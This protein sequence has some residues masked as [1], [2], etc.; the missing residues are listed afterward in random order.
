MLHLHTGPVG[1]IQY[2]AHNELTTPNLVLAASPQ[3]FAVHLFTRI[4]RTSAARQ[5]LFSRFGFS[6]ICLG[7]NFELDWL[8][9]WS[10]RSGF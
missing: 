8:L 3:L 4:T 9:V 1:S 5:Q 2:S 6:S 10:S 7:N